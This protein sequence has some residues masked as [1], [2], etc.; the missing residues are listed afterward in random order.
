MP[1]KEIHRTIAFWISGP[2]NQKIVKLDSYL[3]LIDL[4]GIRV[5]PITFDQKRYAPGRR[6]EVLD[7]LRSSSHLRA[8]TFP[9]LISYL[10]SDDHGKFT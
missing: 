5:V 7:S 4:Q 6:V 3:Q 8:A 10:I 2:P 1:M 9:E